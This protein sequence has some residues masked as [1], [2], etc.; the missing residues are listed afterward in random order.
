MRMLFLKCEITCYI[1]TYTISTKSQGLLIPVS[2]PTHTPQYI[3]ATSH[4]LKR[5]KRRL[6]DLNKRKTSAPR[7][8]RVDVSVDVSVIPCSS[9]SMTAIPFTGAR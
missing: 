4:W 1:Y 2:H 8:T 9:V 5:V 7:G 6:T 3:F